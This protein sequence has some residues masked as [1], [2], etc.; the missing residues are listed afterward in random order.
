MFKLKS[1]V[2]GAVMATAMIAAVAAAVPANAATTQPQYFTFAVQGSY[3]YY[4]TAGLDKGDK[5]SAY[6]YVW[7]SSQSSYMPTQIMGKASNGWVN[8]TLAGSVNLYRGNKY[9][10]R[11]LVYERGQRKANLRAQAPTSTDTLRAEGYWSPDS[12]ATYIVV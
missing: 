12:S 5:S 3:S 1:R 8:A 10:V 6:V 7:S 11:N 4:N 2:L 9:S